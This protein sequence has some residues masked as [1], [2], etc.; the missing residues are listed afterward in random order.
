MI[1][2][3]AAA[4]SCTPGSVRVAIGAALFACT[5][6]A[7][8]ALYRRGGAS[9]TSLYILRSPI[10][11][12]ANVALV[13][14]HHGRRA[15]T[16]VLLLRTGSATATQLAIARSLLNTFKQLLLS[17]AFVYVTY[18]DACAPPPSALCAPPY[19]RR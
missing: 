15:A 14:L 6:A 3:P 4:S 17:V 12:L 5:N 2:P 7:A 19:P 18:A 1:E 10:V 13:A 11:Y 9:V 16:D 8:T